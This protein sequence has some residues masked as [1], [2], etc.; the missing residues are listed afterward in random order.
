VRVGLTIPAVL[1]EEPRF[2]LLFLGQALSIVGDR[3]AMVALPFAVLAVGGSTSDVGLVAAAQALPFVLFGLVAGV[4]ADR[5][6][7]R[8]ILVASDLVRLACQATAGALLLAGEARV[9]HLAVLAAAYGVADAFFGPTFTGLLPQTLSDPVRLQPANAVRSL[10]MSVGSIAGPVLAGLLVAAGGA[11]AA[12]LADAGTFVLSIAFLLA[13]RTGRAVVEREPESFA[14]GLRGGW[15]EVRARSWVVAF[16]GAMIV[17]HVVVLPSVFVLGPVLA[18]RE[19]GGASAWAA[20]TV[21]FGVGSIVG[22][23]LL[24]RWRPRYALRAAAALLVL[25]SMQAV[26][27]GS[28]LPLAGIAILE[29]IA[30]IG[31][32]GFFTLWEISLQEHIPSHAISR[33]SSYDYMLNTGLMPI[34]MAIAGPVSAAVGLHATLGWMSAIGAATGLACLAVP[35]VRHLPRPAG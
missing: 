28:G 5:L 1:R 18:Q 6:D 12:L 16:L 19:L 10:S 23:A 32:S 27:F 13:L 22:D 3:M 8:R 34:G 29:A 30:A 15:R 20:I 26:V 24:L 25:A 4:V 7:R 17:Y 31:V 2:R 11:G 14:A 21:A 33:V 35:A 9:A